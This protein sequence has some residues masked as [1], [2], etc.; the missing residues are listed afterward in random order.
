MDSKRKRITVKDLLNEELLSLVLGKEVQ[1]GILGGRVKRNYLSY[2]IKETYEVNVYHQINLDT[3]GRL[4]KE[5][6][7]TQGYQIESGVNKD[8]M[9]ATVYYSDSYRVEAVSEVFKK[10]SCIFEATNWIAKEKGLL[11]T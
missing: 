7:V 11:C 8:Y 3:L 5:W 6:A 1:F 9:Y 10:D 4:C 2:Q